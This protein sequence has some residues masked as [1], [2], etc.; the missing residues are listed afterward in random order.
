[1]LVAITVIEYKRE[2]ELLG[3]EN[4][5]LVASI[6]FESTETSKKKSKKS[7]KKKR[8][9]EKKKRKLSKKMQEVNKMLRKRL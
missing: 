3:L 6:V 2:K 5:K 7:S 4:A 1:M 8:K 9:K